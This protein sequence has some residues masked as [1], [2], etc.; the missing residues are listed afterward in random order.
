MRKFLI[1]LTLCFSAGALGGLINSLA[2]WFAGKTG[3]TALFGVTLTPAFTQAWV[4]PRIVWGGIWGVL[5]LLPF[6]RKSW[7]P[8]GIIYSIAPTIVQL[9]I[10]FPV[11]AKKGIMGLELG[12]LTPLFVIIFNAVWGISAALWLKVTQDSELP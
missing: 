12:M 6:F 9:F 7:L 2:I 1:N 5:F 10:V 11:Q 8:R 4:Y 3:F